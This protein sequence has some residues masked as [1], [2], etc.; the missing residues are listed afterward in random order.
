MFYTYSVGT[1]A[2]GNLTL[3]G[4]VFKIYRQRIYTTCAYN[5]YIVQLWFR[6]TI[7]DSS[8]CA[9]SCFDCVLTAWHL[10]K[11]Y[12]R[13]QKVCLQLAVCEIL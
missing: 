9:C 11:A 2:T 12:T 7:S 8:N 1:S 4:L 13:S 10:V 6:N 5:I 3:D